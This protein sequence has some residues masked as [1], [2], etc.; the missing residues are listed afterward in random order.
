[1]APFQAARGRTAARAGRLQAH[2]LFPRQAGEVA[3]GQQ[4]GQVAVQVRQ[5]DGIAGPGD[6]AEL[7]AQGDGLLGPAGG[8]GLQGLQGHVGAVAPPLGARIVRRPG[9]LACSRSRARPYAPRSRPM[10]AMSRPW[11]EPWG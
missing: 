4:L 1:M 11:P 7:D 6:K 2:A 9:L 3:A 8:Q 5:Q 10:A